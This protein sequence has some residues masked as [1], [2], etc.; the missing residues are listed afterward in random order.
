MNQQDDAALVKRHLSGDQDAIRELYG[1][2]IPAV[3]N[4]IN[5]L[6]PAGTDVENLTQE[7]FVRAW[8]HLK[9]YDRSKP[10]KTWL[11]AIAKNVLFDDLKKRKTVGFSFL[12]ADSDAF[13]SAD[14]PDER[15]LPDEILARA[16]ADAKVGELLKRLSAEQAAAVVLHVFEDMTFAEIGEVLGEP[17]ETVKT[18]YR[19]ALAKLE[20]MLL[21]NI[22]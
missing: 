21:E 22:G 11:F 14:V 9:R 10:F 7:A 2:H 19:R 4:F 16:Q 20:K 18:R 6:A 5:R 15:P 3:F 12:N 8:N 1:K 17:M 13:A